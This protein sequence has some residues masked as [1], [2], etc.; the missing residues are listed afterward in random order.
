MNSPRSSKKPRTSYYVRFPAF[1]LFT[2]F[3]T[4]VVFASGSIYW[5]MK[6]DNEIEK[7]RRVEIDL[8]NQIKERDLN[9]QQYRQQVDQLER[10]VEIFD[11]I[12]E[13]SHASVPKATQKKIA[14][15]VDETS[16]TFGFDPYLILAIMANES[17]FKPWAESDKGARGLMQLMPST[18]K[19]LARSVK[20]E[21]R[22]LG[23]RDGEELPTLTL[24]DIESNIQLG[25]LYLTHLMVQYHNLED[26]IYA[27]N[28]GPTLF[29]Q[30]RE[31]GGPLPKKYYNNVVKKY[32][33]ITANRKPVEPFSPILIS[34]KTD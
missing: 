28:L 25:V 32:R 20:E 6:K 23:L 19:A 29:N 7:Y 31:Q 11:A 12:R 17:S 26:A 30:R 15:V 1:L 4:L 22:L 27:Y 33:E 21:P 5:I 34:L 9:L 10:R 24:K 16:Q 8:Q 2:I 13:L 3:V 14:K 18:G